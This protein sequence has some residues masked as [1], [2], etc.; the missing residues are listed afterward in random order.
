MHHGETDM[1]R[2][3]PTNGLTQFHIAEFGPSEGFPC[4]GWGVYAI[5]GDDIA[6][7]IGFD[8][9][10]AIVRRDPWTG[11]VGA[12]ASLGD[13]AEAMSGHTLSSKVRS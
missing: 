2:D 3:N 11:Y 7:R 13:V 12:F 5:S 1:S 6:R 4:G 9:G 8:S 10:G